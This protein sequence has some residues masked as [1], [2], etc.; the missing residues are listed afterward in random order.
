[1]RQADVDDATAQRPVDDL[2]DEI[3]DEFAEIDQV[4]TLG[5]VPCRGPLTTENRRHVSVDDVAYLV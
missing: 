5:G 2:T 4:S 1:M 3:T